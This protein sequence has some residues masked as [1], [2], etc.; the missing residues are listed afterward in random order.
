L[1]FGMLD[2]LR[3]DRPQNI[4]NDGQYDNGDD[5][6]VSNDSQ[7]DACLLFVECVCEQSTTTNE[8]FFDCVES[9]D[10]A[11]VGY[12]Q[13]ECEYMIAMYYPSCQS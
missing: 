6:D 1:G 8:D 11:V 12:S 13:S 4:N 9:G 10:A 7:D 5:Q 2:L 3:F